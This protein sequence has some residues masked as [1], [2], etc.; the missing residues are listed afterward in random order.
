VSLPP[1]DGFIYA[2]ADWELFNL[3]RVM[4]K[5]RAKQRIFGH[6]VSSSPCVLL[7]L[8]APV[9]TVRVRVYVGV[10][11]YCLVAGRL[12]FESNQMLDL[13]D[14]IRNDP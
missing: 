7:F 10:T 6:S 12:P 4:A 13:Y 3:Q 2:P 8:S 5:S 1:T 9:L 11:L 14:Q